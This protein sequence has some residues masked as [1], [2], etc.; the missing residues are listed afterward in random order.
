MH[1]RI[2]NLF[3]RKPIKQVKAKLEEECLP[4]IFSSSVLLTSMGVYFA[5]GRVFR[6][7]KEPLSRQYITGVRG[8][9][10]VLVPLGLARMYQGVHIYLK[11]QHKLD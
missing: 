4:C 7:A 2:L 3:N 9:G 6:N 11:D 1:S 10:F 5:S 8:L